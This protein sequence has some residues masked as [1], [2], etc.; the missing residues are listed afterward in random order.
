MYWEDAV[1]LTTG[2][3]DTVLRE[4]YAANGEWSLE[5][6]SV[7]QQTYYPNIAGP[8]YVDCVTPKGP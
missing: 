4:Q 2:G 1:N 5:S 3:Q 7:V 8:G 6:T